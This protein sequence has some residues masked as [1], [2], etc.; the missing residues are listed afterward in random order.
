M[1]TQERINKSIQEGEMGLEEY[2]ASTTLGWSEALEVSTEDS[3]S[4]ERERR[5]EV[6][7]QEG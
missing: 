7:W 2:H 4:K 3:P 5:C 1:K 6:R